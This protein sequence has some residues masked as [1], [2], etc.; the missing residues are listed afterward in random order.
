MVHPN[1]AVL[2]S[3]CHAASEYTTVV[4]G[5]LVSLGRGV[6]VRVGVLTCSESHSL[7]ALMADEMTS[8][9]DDC[10][11]LKIRLLRASQIPQRIHGASCPETPEGGRH[12]RV[13]RE[14][15]QEAK[16]TSPLTST[17]C[18]KGARL[19]TF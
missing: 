11:L 5:G 15:Q 1:P 12:S 19:H 10:L 6:G 16:S 4:C 17:L 9:G 8:S 3:A 14:C 18:E 2:R 7:A 13:H